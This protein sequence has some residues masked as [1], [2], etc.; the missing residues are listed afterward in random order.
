MSAPRCIVHADMDAFYASIEQRDDP[1]LRGRPVIVGATSPRG[2]VAAASYEARRFGVRSAMP[3]FK[4]RQLCPEGVF[5]PSNM[6]RYAAVSRQIQALFLDFTP[7]VE[8]L[9]LDEAF[10]DVS[11]SVHLFGDALS[12]ARELK[13]RVYTETELRVSVGVAPSKLVAKIACNLG[14]PDGLYIVPEGAARELLD[15]LEIGALWGVG[16]VLEQRLRAAGIHSFG[17]LVR[18]DTQALAPLLGRRA[19]ELQA[20]ARGEDEREVLADRAPKSIGEENTFETDV[21][22]E[23]RILEVLRVHADAVA[24]RLRRAGYQGRTVSVK[25]KLAHA[26]RARVSERGPHY[27]L[28]TR[29]RTLAEATDDAEQIAT[30]ARELWASA[31]LTQP[32]RLLGVS[33]SALSA[34]GAQPPQQLALFDAADARGRPAEFA[35]VAR[36]SRRPLGPTLDAITERFGSGAIQR[37]VAA[38]GKVT[39]G[40]GIKRGES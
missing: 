14:K 40:R 1:S 27:P 35:R 8:P 29:S 5:L 20:L 38:P 37:A 10:L 15:P 26:D 4:A 39:H 6:Q 18:H 22:A 3:G 30:V 34:T 7:L 31:A 12:L 25:I 23:P 28:L 33:V 17:D 11:G 9:A 24:R 36:N 16:P 32:I 13:R 21:S 2:V 19:R